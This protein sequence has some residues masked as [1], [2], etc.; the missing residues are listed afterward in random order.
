[1][2][3]SRFYAQAELMLTV[4]PDVMA[5]PHFALKGGTAINLFVRDMPRLSVD[6]DLTYLPMQE[7]AESLDGISN[8]LERIAARI[9]KHDARIV[10]HKTRAKNSRTISKL[11]VDRGIHVKIEPNTVIRGAA[12]PC[13]ERKL[14]VAARDLFRLDVE[15]RTLSLGDLY[16]GKICAALDRKHPRDFFD[17]KVLLE[18]EGLT[19]DRFARLRGLGMTGSPGRLP[20]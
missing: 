11:V 17:I 1:M 2:R 6:I 14:C 19:D 8:A 12:F 3:D 15:V 4:L 18:N 16:G 13:A 10:V 7:R 20:P 5:E 9:S